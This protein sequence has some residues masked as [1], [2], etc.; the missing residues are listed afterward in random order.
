MYQIIPP[1]STVLED[2][3]LSYFEVYNRTSSWVLHRYILRYFCF[4]L[5]LRVQF[6]EA[7]KENQKENPDKQLGQII[8]IYYPKNQNIIP[9]I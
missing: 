2:S 5:F 1:R 8:T 7:K 6:V 3:A 9:Q 4:V